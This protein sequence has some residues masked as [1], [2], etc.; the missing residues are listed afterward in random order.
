MHY[1]N[2]RPAKKGYIVLARTYQGTP[3]TG[4]VISTNEQSD[5]CNLQVCPIDP[6]TSFSVT[7]KEAIHADDIEA[8]AIA[9][10]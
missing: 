10:D 5:S 1:A 7:A 8:K 6:S 2:G 4:V 9:D 3:Y